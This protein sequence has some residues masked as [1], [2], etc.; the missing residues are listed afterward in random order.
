MRKFEYRNIDLEINE[1]YSNILCKSSSLIIFGDRRG[2]KV[3]SMLIFR[4]GYTSNIALFTISSIISPMGQAGV[5]K[6]IRI[7]MRVFLLSIVIS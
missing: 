4:A 7:W 2:S 3:I 5:V 1:I 6:V